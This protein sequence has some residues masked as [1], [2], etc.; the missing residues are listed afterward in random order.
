MQTLVNK[1]VVVSTVY[2]SLPYYRNH[3][4]GPDWTDSSM[5]QA[6]M[7]PGLEMCREAWP[8]EKL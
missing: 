6:G 1:N 8:G 5:G 3:T 7:D 4:R 2:I